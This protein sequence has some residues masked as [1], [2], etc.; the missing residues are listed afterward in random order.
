MLSGPAR[1]PPSQPSSEQAHNSQEQCMKLLSCPQG[2]LK[3]ALWVP[4]TS[5]STSYCW[6]RLVWVH[7]CMNSIKTHI[8]FSGR[9]TLSGVH[10]STP[11]TSVRTA[12]EKSPLPTVTQVRNTFSP[13]RD[14]HTKLCA[15]MPYESKAIGLQYKIFLSNTGLKNSRPWFGPAT[16]RSLRWSPLLAAH[17][18]AEVIIKSGQGSFPLWRKQN[19][20]LH[21]K[22]PAKGAWLGYSSV[23]LL[24]L[25]TPLQL[26]RAVG[27]VC[28][29]IYIYIYI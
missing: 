7:L 14:R 3:S 12:G 24:F 6:V 15:V 1:N 4:L 25:L 2:G 28:G 11:N 10:S 9:L 17:P 20:S 5:S 29:H 19:M 27:Y 16:V 13:P 22:V 26:C 8:S 23:W 18:S 21:L